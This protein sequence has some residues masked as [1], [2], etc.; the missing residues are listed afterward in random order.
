MLS[1]NSLNLAIRIK[2][3]KKNKKNDNFIATMIRRLC[4]NMKFSN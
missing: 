3:K 1:L 4:V 2:E